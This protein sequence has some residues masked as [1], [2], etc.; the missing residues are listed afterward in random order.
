MNRIR[1]D[2]REQP[3]PPATE[4]TPCPL[5]GRAARY[6]GRRDRLSIFECVED[7][8]MISIFEVIDPAAAE[9]PGGGR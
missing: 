7:E 3:P 8:C 2:I 9:R 5:C 4:S 1:S 6:C